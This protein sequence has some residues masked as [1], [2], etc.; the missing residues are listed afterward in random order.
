ML[1]S[2]KIFWERSSRSR[3]RPQTRLSVVITTLLGL[4]MEQLLKVTALLP[5]T[6][7]AHLTLVQYKITVGQLKLSHYSHVVQPSTLSR[8]T[9]VSSAASALTNAV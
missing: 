7:P 2:A 8:L 6:L 1:V 5:S 9:P 4:S 3:S